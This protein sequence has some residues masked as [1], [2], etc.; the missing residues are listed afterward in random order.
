V[1]RGM[2]VD[3]VVHGVVGCGGDGEDLIA[4]EV[5]AG[6][7]GAE[8]GGCSG[9][10]VDMLGVRELSTLPAP[11]KW[12]YSMVKLSYVGVESSF[13]TLSHTHP[14]PSSNTT[15]RIVHICCVPGLRIW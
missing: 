12:M 11:F 8:V 10:R 3:A 14:C 15:S 5:V 13:T 6:E 1:P 9:T 7:R 4:T 2:A